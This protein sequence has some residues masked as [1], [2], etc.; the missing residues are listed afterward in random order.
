MV[1]NRGLKIDQTTEHFQNFRMLLDAAE[2]GEL[3]SVTGISIEHETKLLV[4]IEDIRDELGIL[5]L[6]LEDQ[7]S[8]VNNLDDLLTP[9]E[10]VEDTN[11]GTNGRKEHV[12]KGNRVLQS[13]LAR[14]SRMET[15]TARSIQSVS[16]NTTA[17]QELLLT[18]PSSAP[19]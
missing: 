10:P 12:L 6:I 2:V 15:L 7:Q 19:C 18:L 16:Q 5:R 8:V 3:L 9:S 11:P 4:E 13:H 1:T 17:T 14:A